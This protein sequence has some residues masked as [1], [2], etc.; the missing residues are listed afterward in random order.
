MEA[1]RKFCE[2][3]KFYVKRPGSISDGLFNFMFSTYNL[4]SYLLE[5]FSE[6]NRRRCIPSFSPL[7]EAIQN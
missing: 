2:T 7:A 6:R 1:F 3:L 5:T 4:D